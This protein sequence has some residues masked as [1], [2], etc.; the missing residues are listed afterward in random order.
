MTALAPTAQ[1]LNIAPISTGEQNLL[2]RLSWRGN[3]F[4]YFYYLYFKPYHGASRHRERI[5]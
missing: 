1:N 2:A 3:G 5:P 4:W